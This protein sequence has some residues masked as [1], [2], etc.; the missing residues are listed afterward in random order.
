MKYSN[1]GILIFAKAPV[2]GQV[3]TRL[4]PALGRE[5]ATRLYTQLLHNLV[6]RLAKEKLASIELWCAPD[7]THPEFQKWK[8]LYPGL[9]LHVQQGIDL[10]ERMAYAVAEARRRHRHLILIGID[11]P[12]LTISM[13]EQVF[14]WLEE[15]MDAVLG[16]AEDGGYVLLGLKQ[17]A[18]C[19]FQDIPW[20]SEVVGQMTRQCMRQ[21][22][23]QWRELPELWDLDRPEDLVRLATTASSMM[24]DS[25]PVDG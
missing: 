22:Q 11:S 18:D 21:M 5:G 24:L 14:D 17:S 1:A 19:L 20:G 16:P 25:S 9:T 10:G 15:G 12:A 7:T 2:A 23:W 8:L 13:L 4:I 3:K 6:H